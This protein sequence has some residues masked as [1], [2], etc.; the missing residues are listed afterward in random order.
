MTALCFLTMKTHTFGV[1]LGQVKKHKASQWNPNSGRIWRCQPG[2]SYSSQPFPRSVKLR[3]WGRDY[4]GLTFM[5]W[6]ILQ[7]KEVCSEH[8]P[9]KSPIQAK[10][11]QDLVGNFLSL[12]YL[13]FVSTSKSCKIFGTLLRDRIR[14][15]H[16]PFPCE[17]LILISAKLGHLL[18]FTRVTQEKMQE[19]P[20]SKS[21]M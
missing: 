5:E 2:S 4:L 13:V 6:G 17:S 18:I 15:R 10:V 7:A 12:S 1:W 14:D 21:D 19:W 9:S 16:L 3:C 11:Q 20:W 8:K